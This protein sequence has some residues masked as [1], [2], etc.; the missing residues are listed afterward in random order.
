MKSLFQLAAPL[1]I[2]LLQ[3]QPV[4]NNMICNIKAEV[5]KTI[6]VEILSIAFT[7]L[8]SVILTCIV[9]YSLYI[10]G[11]NINILLLD[12]VNGPQLS[13]LI[14][15]LIAVIST[16]ALVLILK[17]KI[18]IKHKKT[19]DEMNADLKKTIINFLDGFN[20]GIKKQ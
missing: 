13:I 7:I 9:I 6:R 10:I 12:I 3:T 19:E 1:V 17:I 4:F 11:K 8:I 5:K 20:K 14:F 18:P 16:F 2:D 15:S